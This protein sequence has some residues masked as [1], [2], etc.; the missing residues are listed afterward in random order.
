MRESQ[1]LADFFS[2][3][4]YAPNFHRVAPNMTFEAYLLTS[5]AAGAEGKQSAPAVADQRSRPGAGQ[6]SALRFGDLPFGCPLPLQAPR[7]ENLIGSVSDGGMEEIR[8]LVNQ[9]HLTLRWWEGIASATFDTFV[10]RLKLL[11]C[12]SD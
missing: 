12:L 6:R 3:L 4:V 8:G 11:P 7:H 9:T 10:L 5:E 1:T 2:R